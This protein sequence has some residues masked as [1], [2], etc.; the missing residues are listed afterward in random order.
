MMDMTP[1]SCMTKEELQNELNKVKAHYASCQAQGLN[2]NMARGKPAKAQL[3]LVSD[4]LTVMQKP[5]DVERFLHLARACLTCDAYEEL[6][7]I[8]CPVFVI[9]GSQDLVLTGEA[10][11]EIA[12]K[13]GCELYLY[14]D[15][16]HAA[17][18]EAKDFVPRVLE[19][20]GK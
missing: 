9:G 17:Y 7:K 5:K 1:Y 6:E 14:E 8:Q 16:G 15:L 12:E 19:F 10:S 13:L 2:L 4:L 3:D 11:R 18:E 20:F